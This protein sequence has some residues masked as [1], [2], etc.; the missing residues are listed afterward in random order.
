MSRNFPD[1]RAWFLLLPL[2]AAYAAMS[3]HASGASRSFAFALGAGGCALA[4]LVVLTG[5]RLGHRLLAG[6]GAWLADRRAVATVFI[7]LPWLAILVVALT[8]GLWWTQRPPALRFF[9]EYSGA[10][11]SVWCSAQ[12]DAQRT[13]TDLRRL[14]LSV[15]AILA[16]MGVTGSAFGLNPFGCAVSI[17]LLIAACTVLLFASLASRTAGLQLFTS[18]VAI[19]VGL[20]IGEGVVRFLRVGQTAQE[21]NSREYALQFF[22]LTPPGAA[23]VNRPG[24]LDEVPPALVEINS[25]GIRGPE[26]AER[27]TDVLLL[28]DSF[29]EARQLPWAQTTGARLDT[30][31]KERGRAVRVRAHGMRGWSPLLEWNWYL[32]VG[33]ALHP[34]LVVLFFFWND[35]WASG[36]E[37]ATFHAVLRPDGR[38]EAFALPLDPPWIWYSHVQLIRLAEETW[39]RLGVDD[40][41]RAF[42]ASSARVTQG[43]ILSLGDAQR[44]ARSGAAPPFTTAELR[45]LLEERDALLDPALQ[46]VASSGFWSTLRPRALWS[47][48]QQQAAEVTEREL[49][50]F[51]ADVARDGGQLAILYVANPLQVD[52]RECSVGRLFDRIGSDVVLPPDSGIQSWL[53]DVTAR[54]NVPFA[55][56]TAAMRAFDAG[57]AAASFTPLYLRADCH[58]SARGHAFIAEFLAGQSWLAGG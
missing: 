45:A 32:K 39:R 13:G 15:A 29:V 47:A 50:A 54:L 16:T 6:A 25:L 55:D 19:A 40:L 17:C 53:R 41:K 57:Q 8:R 27:R 11:W 37:A 2:V 48:E 1:R 46:R 4:A 58:W 24:P 38:P 10:L 7:L 33:R 34:R 56:P 3:L 23:F 35:L 26:L 22:S 30:L 31:M 44:V 12:V 5:S 51:A 49:A 18:I 21:T 28:G 43:R 36:S 42:V 52:S 9:V 20:A 14:L